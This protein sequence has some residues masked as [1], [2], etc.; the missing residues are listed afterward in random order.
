[1]RFGPSEWDGQPSQL[2]CTGV[3]AG[4]LMDLVKATLVRQ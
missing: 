1:M 3:K 2:V 4:A